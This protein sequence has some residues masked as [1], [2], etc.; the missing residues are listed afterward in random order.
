MTVKVA[1]LRP[2]F[3]LA[4][5]RRIVAATHER[6]VQSTISLT[7]E[8]VPVVFHLLRESVQGRIVLFIRAS[9]TCSAQDHFSCRFQKVIVES[10]G[11]L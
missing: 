11:L 4:L 10:L 9:C 8:F 3:F 6:D 2:R 1:L 5:F 7:K